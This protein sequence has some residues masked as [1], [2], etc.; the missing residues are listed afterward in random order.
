MKVTAWFDTAIEVD[1]SIDQ[2]I[3][4]LGELN[5]DPGDQSTL[6]LLSTCV[7]LIKEIPDAQIEELNE[8]QCRL[9]ADVMLTQAGRYTAAKGGGE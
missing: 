5:K 2:I 7:G 1:V 3:E 9:I 6:R 4:E 8:D